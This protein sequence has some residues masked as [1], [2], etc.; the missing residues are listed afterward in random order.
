VRLTGGKQQRVMSLIFECLVLSH[1]VTYVMF[2]WMDSRDIFQFGRLFQKHPKIFA[3][4]HSSA[5]FLDL[6]CHRC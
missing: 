1:A 6:T 2:Y 4:K 3:K 5:H